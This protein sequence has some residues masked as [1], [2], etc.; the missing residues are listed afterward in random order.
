ML[1]VFTTGYSILFSSFLMNTTFCKA[2]FLTI[3]TGGIHV[4]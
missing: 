4:Y 1:S 2:V 3:T